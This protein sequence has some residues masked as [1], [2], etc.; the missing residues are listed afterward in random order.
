MRERLREALD[1]LRS[2]IDFALVF[3]SAA[4]GKDHSDSDTHLMIVGSVD[5]IEINGALKSV[6]KDR[7]RTV[8]VSLYSTE[9]WQTKRFNSYICRILTGP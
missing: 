7:A 8:H 9:E 1:S 6:E 3:G 4:I 5:Y 2:K